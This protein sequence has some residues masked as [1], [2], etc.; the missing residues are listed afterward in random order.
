VDRGITTDTNAVRAAI[1]GLTLGH[2]ED[3]P[4]SYSRA[5]YETYADPSVGWR[6]GAKKIVIMFGD[7]IPHD[8]AYATG[9]DPGRDGEVGTADDLYFEDVVAGL[10]SNGI[11]VLALHSGIDNKPWLYMAEET[12]GHISRVNPC[13]GLT[14]TRGDSQHGGGRGGKNRRTHIKS[15]DRL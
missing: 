6:T 13:R 11:T 15:R 9:I 3:L 7:D 1:N 8:P 5:L 4:E 2:G 10:K 14:N 12:E